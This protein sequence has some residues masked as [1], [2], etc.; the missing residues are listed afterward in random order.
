LPGQI[1]QASVASLAILEMKCIEYR[2]ATDAEVKDAQSLLTF[3][4]DP[5]IDEWK[6]AVAGY[7]KK[8]DADPN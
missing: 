6:K 4:D 5:L 8:I 7:R 1:Y 2:R 3:K